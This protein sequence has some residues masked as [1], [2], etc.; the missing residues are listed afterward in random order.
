MEH[1]GLFKT[2]IFLISHMLSVLF[3]I[4]LCIIHVIMQLVELDSR[5]KLAESKDYEVKTAFL[6]WAISCGC[7]T[8]YNEV[9]KTLKEVGRIKYLRPLY[10]ALM[11]GNEDDKV[12]AKTVFSEARESYHPIAQ[13]VVE[14]ILSNNL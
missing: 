13:S 10:T 3:I 4:I 7:K 2:T 1:S 14:G 6:K 8:Y 12:F 5:Y 9:E 11:S